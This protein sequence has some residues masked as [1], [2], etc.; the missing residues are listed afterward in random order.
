MDRQSVDR[1]QTPP[2][3]VLPQLARGVEG[4]GVGGLA[5]QDLVPD[6]DQPRCLGVLRLFVW[7]I[8]CIYVC[9]CFKVIMGTCVCVSARALVGG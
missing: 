2:R 7:C 1:P 9:V 3:T 5:L 8:V 4:V 6:D